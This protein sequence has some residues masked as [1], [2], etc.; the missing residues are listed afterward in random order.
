MKYTILICFILLIFCCGCLQ[1]KAQQPISTPVLTP[2]PIPAAI[3]G[4][5][6]GTI[7]FGWLTKPSTY[8]IT[9]YPY[10]QFQAKPLTSDGVPV[11]GTWKQCF[12]DVECLPTE[13]MYQAGQKYTTDNYIIQFNL[14]IFG[15]S[16]KIQDIVLIKDGTL[17][18]RGTQHRI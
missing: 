18:F 5:W 11:S 16:T 6:D 8:H 15:Q 1:T 12:T 10:H 2:T 4:T 17:N 3:I 14:N 13:M 9:F 7:D